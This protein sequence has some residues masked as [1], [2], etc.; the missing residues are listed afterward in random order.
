MSRDRARALRGNQTDVERLVWFRL[1]NRKFSGFKFRR[2]VPIGPY[3]ADFVCYD[4]R[5]IVELDGEQ[6]AAQRDYDARRTDWLEGQGFR[7]MRFWNFEVHE[8]WD[9]VEEAI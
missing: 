3:I 9:V 1:R 5:L 6:H 7:V 8:E 4:R 2:Q